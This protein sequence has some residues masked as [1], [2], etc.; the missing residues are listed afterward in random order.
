M[1]KR[2]KSKKWAF[3][4]FSLLFVMKVFAQPFSNSWV[5]LNQAYRKIKIGKEGVYKIDFQKMVN[6]GF[7]STIDPRNVQLFCKGVEVPLY[8][9]GQ[10]DGVLDPSDFFLFHAT[11]NDGWLDSSL[12]VPRTSQPQSFVSLYGDTSVYFLTVGNQPG[13]RFQDFDGS[14]TVGNPELFYYHTV[15]RVDTTSYYLGVPYFSNYFSE[16]G[17]GEGWMGQR[18]QVINNPTAAPVR[19]DVNFNFSFLT[20]FKSTQAVPCTLDLQF[21]GVSN[22]DVSNIP[23]GYNHHI[24]VKQGT[25]VLL[26]TLFMD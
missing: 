4:A 6:G 9:E 5:N 14:N 25:T 22:A 10:S 24:Q 21:Y 17:E 11:P 7:P 26:D 13:L 23:S 15:T 12:Y 2:Y 19:Q 1:S 18:V 20:P 16:M 8:A 3:L